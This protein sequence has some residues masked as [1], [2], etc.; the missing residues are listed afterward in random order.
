MRLHDDLL[1]DKK[2]TS[3]KAIVYNMYTGKLKMD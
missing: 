3:I 1:G 2:W